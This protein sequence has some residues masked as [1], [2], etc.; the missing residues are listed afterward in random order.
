MVVN[1]SSP[2]GFNPVEI[3][4]G[5][6]KGTAP[7]IYVYRLNSS[8]SNTR[9]W[10][11]VDTVNPFSKNLNRG[12]NIATARIDQDGVD[13]IIVSLVGGGA[14]GVEIW[15]GLTTDT[16]DTRLQSFQTFAKLRSSGSPVHTFAADQ[17][18][19]G[20]ADRLVAVQGTDGSAKGPRVFNLS[21]AT[22]VA[23]FQLP[24]HYWVTAGIKVVDPA[25]IAKYYPAPI[26]TRPASSLVSESSSPGNLSPKS[27]S[28]TDFVPASTASSESQ[29]TPNPWRR[30]DVDGDGLVTPR[31]ALLVVNALNRVSR[32]VN[33]ID[34]F[35]DVNDDGMLT[36]LDA[37][38]V[39]NDLNNS[40]KGE[41]EGNVSIGTKTAL[42]ADAVF[43]DTDDG[44][45]WRDLDFIARWPP[46]RQKMR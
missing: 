27:T 19:D 28:F 46:R 39:I 15:S 23:E 44:A 41:G 9:S 25:I 17:N 30:S 32:T 13:D 26:S 5:S 10:T 22:Q 6:R 36:P 8:A 45:F 34:A 1:P 35:P 4:V 38:L 18:G 16:T 3:I 42:A 2:S 20:I 43:G 12:L 33:G 31:D 40:V 29:A 21:T 7:T 14:S 24:L 11:L 37:L